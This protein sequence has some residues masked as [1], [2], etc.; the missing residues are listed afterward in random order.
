MIKKTGSRSR[1]IDKKRPEQIVRRRKGIC[2]A[3]FI[4]SAECCQPQNMSYPRQLQWKQR[5]VEKLLGKFGRVQP[6]IGM[7][8]PY[9]YRKTRCRR[10]LH[11]HKTNELFQEF[12]SPA[13]IGCFVEHC[14]TEDQKADEIIGTIRG[15]MHQ[16]KLTPYNEDTGRGFLRHVLVKRGFSSNQIMVVLVTERRCSR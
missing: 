16:F 11:L 10:R 9:H 12:I 13:P 7:E 6:I 5:K 3:R 1:L 15:M 14:M 4:G 8:T 2:P